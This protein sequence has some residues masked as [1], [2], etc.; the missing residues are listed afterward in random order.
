MPPVTKN[1][2]VDEASD[3]K[4]KKHAN[5]GKQGTRRGE[6]EERE[7]IIGSF[8][9]QKACDWHFFLVR[10]KLP[11]PPPTTEERRTG[12]VKAITRKV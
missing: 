10:Y 12:A 11:K 3:Y 6:R 2:I 5:E 7:G 4:R 8:A 1:K 9:T